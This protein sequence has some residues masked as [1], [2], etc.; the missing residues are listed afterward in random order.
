[1]SNKPSLTN[2]YLRRLR[3]YI[4]GLRPKSRKRGSKESNFTVYILEFGSALYLYDML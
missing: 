3:G 1:M 2:I 4:C